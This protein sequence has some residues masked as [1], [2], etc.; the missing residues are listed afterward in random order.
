MCQGGAVIHRSLLGLLPVLPFLVLRNTACHGLGEQTEA[1]EFKQESFPVH[2]NSSSQQVD[3]TDPEG[4]ST[5]H[6]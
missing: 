5:R 3:L 6:G 1:R 2:R 4:A